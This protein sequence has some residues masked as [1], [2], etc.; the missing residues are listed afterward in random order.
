MITKE[1]VKKLAALGRIGV[2]D[3]EIESL[4]GD[5]ERVLFFVSKLKKVSF[6]GEVFEDGMKNDLREDAIFG[7]SGEYTEDLL[8]QAP[9]LERGFVKVKKVL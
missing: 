3:K 5:M 2:D 9:E 6:A 8:K 1:E 7:K 4:R